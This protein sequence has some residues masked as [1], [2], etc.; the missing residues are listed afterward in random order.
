MPPVPIDASTS[1]EGVRAVVEAWVG[2]HVPVKWQEAAERGGRDA[3]RAVRSYADYE[4][5]YPTL[6]ASG[7][8]V[9]TW[10]ESCGGLA[11]TQHQAGVVEAVL[12]RYNLGRLNIIG[13]GAIA[14][15]LFSYGTEEQRRRFLPPMVG[16]EEKWTQLLSEPGAGPTW[17]R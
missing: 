17:R 7:L 9:A 11:L 12:G 5:W 6:A 15:A 13:L 2:E 14:P 10:P 16:N 3:I 4:Q 8:A 1:P